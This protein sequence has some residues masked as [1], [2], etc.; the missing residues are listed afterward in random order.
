MIAITLVAY[1]PLLIITII[2]SPKK[3]NYFYSTIGIIVTLT[4]VIAI[5]FTPIY[6]IINSLITKTKSGANGREILWPWCWEKFKENP[7]FGYGLLSDEPVPTVRN[8]VPVVLAHNTILQW[9]TSLGIVGSVLMLYF[10]YEKYK[11][12]FIHFTMSKFYLVSIIIIIA[13]SGMVDQA[14]SMDVFVALFSYIL[15]AACE[16]ENYKYLAWS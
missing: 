14:A 9:L 5:F 13:L 1:I 10:Y 11:I 7:V 4:I 12:T 8:V 16:Q 3:F 15:I 2:Y 6:E